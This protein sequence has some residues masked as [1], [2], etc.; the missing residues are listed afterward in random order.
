MTNVGISGLGAVGSQ[1]LQRLQSRNDINKLVIY[2]SDYSKLGKY[3]RKN[4]QKIQ[5][6]SSPKLEQGDI[7]VLFLC[8]PSGQHLEYAHR[9]VR[10]GISIIS[11]SDRISDVTGMLSMGEIA[12]ESGCIVVA[13]AGFSPGLTWTS[14]D[15]IVTWLLR[16]S[17]SIPIRKYLSEG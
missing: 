6:A 17:F 5:V 13:G 15:Q 9:A 11:V 14:L 3:S 8:T 10:Q 12:R 16:S 1:L 4:S 7:D 2:D